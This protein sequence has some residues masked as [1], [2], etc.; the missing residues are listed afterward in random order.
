L[1][2]LENL[3]TAVKIGDKVMLTTGA[4]TGLGPDARSGD[5]DFLL[6]A[7]SLVFSAFGNSKRKPLLPIS[8]FPDQKCADRGFRFVDLDILL[9]TRHIN[10]VI[11]LWLWLEEKLTSKRFLE[12]SSTSTPIVDQL[13]SV[14]LGSRISGLLLIFFEL[15]P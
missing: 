4:M 2:V 5:L 13:Q 14:C 12:H 8:R 9:N 1:K 15:I 10:T 6:N 3:L 7:Q 11:F